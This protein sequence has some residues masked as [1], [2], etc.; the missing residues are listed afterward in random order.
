MPGDGRGGRRAFEGLRS[1]GQKGPAALPGRWLEIRSRTI[2]TQ[3]TGR[4]N[5]VDKLFHEGAQMGPV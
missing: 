2:L 1:T 4:N 5:V 3:M